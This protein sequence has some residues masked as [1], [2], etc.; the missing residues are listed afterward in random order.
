ME[1]LV[2]IEFLCA[3]SDF[4]FYDELLRKHQ[5]LYRK[6]KPLPNIYPY[7]QDNS[8][9]HHKEYALAVIAAD[10]EAE[11]LVLSETAKLTL[12]IDFIAPTEEWKLNEVLRGEMEN[13]ITR[14]KQGRKQNKRSTKELRTAPTSL[15]GVR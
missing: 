8:D 9:S 10:P 3:N 12:P 6:L 5:T 7:R 2:E 14:P 11:R 1:Y 15:R 4:P 13:Q